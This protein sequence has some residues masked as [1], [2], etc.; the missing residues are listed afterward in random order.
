MEKSLQLLSIFGL[1]AVFI[2]FAGSLSL[3]HLVQ[4]EWEV[5]KVCYYRI[6]TIGILRK[7]IPMLVQLTPHFLLS[8]M[9]KHFPHFTRFLNNVFFCS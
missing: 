3:S 9:T 8:L 2:Q 1:V 4:D 6:V 7:H 5:F